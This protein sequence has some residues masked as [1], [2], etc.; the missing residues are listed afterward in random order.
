MKNP[1]PISELESY[2]EDFNASEYTNEDLLTLVGIA[3]CIRTKSL[4]ELKI[5]KHP[6]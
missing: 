4:D 3:I 2:A 6:V 1:L 5:R